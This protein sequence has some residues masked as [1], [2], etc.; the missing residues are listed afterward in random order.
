M[1]KNNDR[2]LIAFQVNDE[3]YK[4]LE[5]YALADNRSVSSAIRTILIK[6]LS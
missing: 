2:K 6:F 1:S 5:D 3:L 4:S